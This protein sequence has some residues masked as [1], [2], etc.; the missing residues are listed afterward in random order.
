MRK[1]ITL[2]AGLFL[3]ANCMAGDVSPGK[4][5]LSLQFSVPESPDFSLPT[6]SMEQCFT[7]EQASHPEALL[8]GS[9]GA[10]NC[11]TSNVKDNGRTMTFNVS[12]GGSYAIKGTGSVTYT[13]NAFNGDL[14][15]DFNLEGKTIKSQSHIEAK[16][17]GNCQ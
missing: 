17:V 6:Q 3:A 9:Q 15:L 2:F 4:W 5:N 8:V 11:T 12:C 13:S 14:S 1:I 7:A 16:R 10:N